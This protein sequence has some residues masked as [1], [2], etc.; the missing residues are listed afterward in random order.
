M[1]QPT[2]FDEVQRVPTPIAKAVAEVMPALT[3][4]VISDTSNT[5]RPTS[6]TNPWARVGR[7]F[8]PTADAMEAMHLAGLNWSVNKVALRTEDLAPVPGWYGIR[9][10]DNGNVLGIVGE[11]YL[12][13]QNSEAF[14]FFRDLAGQAKISYETAGAFNGGAITWC[15]A[16]LP[17]L[18]IRIGDD[19][20][21]AY[22]LISNGH[23]GTKAL[24]I[25]P[26]LLRIACM[27]MLNMAENQ[28]RERRRHSHGLEAGFV[29]RHTKGMKEALADIQE[30]YARTLAAHKVTKEAWE[31]L[32]RTPMTTAMQK[33]FFERSFG[34][35]GPDESDRAKTIRKNRAERLQAILASPTSNV[36]GT[37]GSAF[38]LFQSAV[39]FVD[40]DRTTR[41]SE[42]GDAG[43]SRLFSA[44]F[45]SGA[46]IKARA[47]EA[48]LDLAA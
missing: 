18:G 44:T 46:D 14:S 26:T 8:T 6:R 25:G 4:N 37:A 38:A 24:T 11:G 40:H 7:S 32:A 30:A 20:S 13:L 19:E 45:G 29:V 17:D 2:L 31:H 28:I 12:P 41:T 9:R 22:L 16:H 35:E 34:K 21:K 47:F 5:S 23:T 48:I 10:S 33:A 39:E 36:K 15:L 3:R 43:E 27:N 42:G 1:N